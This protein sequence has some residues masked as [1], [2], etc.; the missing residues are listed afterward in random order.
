MTPTLRQIVAR[1]TPALIYDTN[2]Q[3]VL[4]GGAA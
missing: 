4:V 2:P 3:L 1:E